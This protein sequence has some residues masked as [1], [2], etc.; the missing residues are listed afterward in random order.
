MKQIDDDVILDEEPLFN[1]PAIDRYSVLRGCTKTMQN[2]F[3]C[4]LYILDLSTLYNDL[5][6]L[7]DQTSPLK[8]KS[9][10]ETAE[11]AL[12]SRTASSFLLS[13]KCAS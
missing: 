8:Q 9:C 3:K 13:E 11:R 12:S 6:R 2:L 4:F 5:Q 10:C 1:R 7:S